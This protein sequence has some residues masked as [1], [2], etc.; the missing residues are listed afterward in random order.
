MVDRINFSEETKKTV[1]ERSKSHCEGC[2]KNIAFNSRQ[3]GDW[4]AWN[5][6]HIRPLSLGGSNSLRNL[7][8]LCIDCNQIKKKAM[9]N[10]EFMTHMKPEGWQNWLKH[11]WK[12]DSIL[13]LFGVH[14]KAR[15][16]WKN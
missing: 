7:Q 14:P 3:N 2:G 6:D 16:I 8:A 12:D 4:G 9:R 13:N 10:P 11:Q 1:F 5:V 15:R